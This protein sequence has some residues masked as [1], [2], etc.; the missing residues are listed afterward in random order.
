MTHVG[1]DRDLRDLFARLKEEDRAH[2]P[3]FRDVRTTAVHSRKVG[4]RWALS[5]AAGAAAAIIVVALVITEDRGS[6]QRAARSPQPSLASPLVQHSAW[7]SPT[8]FLLDT[9]GSALLRTVPTFGTA[10]W[11]GTSSPTLSPRSRS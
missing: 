7:I 9:P 10:R 8:D 4:L 6:T 1:P 3:P 5:L 2:A 11:I